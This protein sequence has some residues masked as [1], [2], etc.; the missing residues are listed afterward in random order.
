MAAVTTQWV[1]DAM[2]AWAPSRWAM[3]S[4]NVGLLIGDRTRPISR[5]LTAL[6]L[7]EAV[8][9]EAVQGRFDVVVT[10]HPLISRYVQPINSI[11]AD[12][13]LGKKILPHVAPTISKKSCLTPFLIAVP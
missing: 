8:L 11:T 1:I 5:I 4:D 6:D 12:N 2:E 13:V 3:E 9:R 10:H 7:S